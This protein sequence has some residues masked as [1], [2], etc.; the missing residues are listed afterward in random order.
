MNEIFGEFTPDQI[1]NYF[2]RTVFAHLPGREEICG[3][4][5]EDVPFAIF[6]AK[7]VLSIG[8]TQTGWRVEVVRKTPLEIL[9]AMRARLTALQHQ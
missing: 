3:T 5:W 7:R 2:R 6:G 8:P 9:E 4:H 1:E